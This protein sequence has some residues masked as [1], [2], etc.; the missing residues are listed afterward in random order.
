MAL[1]LYKTNIYKVLIKESANK[2]DIIRYR[3]KKKK[4]IN[5]FE[6]HNYKP[7]FLLSLG[8]KSE[9][10][11]NVFKKPLMSELLKRSRL[12]PNSS[13]DLFIFENSILS[14]E[15]LNRFDFKSGQFLPAKSS[16]SLSPGAK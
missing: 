3:K 16:K 12:E 11:G 15:V 2:E 1:V 5:T 14:G 9:F 8:L 10:I 4:P 7:K 6:N 13:C